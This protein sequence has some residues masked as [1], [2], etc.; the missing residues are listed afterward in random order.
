MASASKVSFVVAASVAAV[1]ALKDQAGLCR[2]NYA[3]RSLQQRAKHGDIAL[4]SRATK[5]SSPSALS[6]WRKGGEGAAER[7]RRT[8]ESLSKRLGRWKISP[9]TMLVVVAAY[10]SST[11]AGRRGAPRRSMAG[12][13]RRHIALAEVEHG[14]ACAKEDA[15][16][17]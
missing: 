15:G 13:E 8:E 17:V 11:S 2:W 7:A 10:A 6:K 3:L 4:F 1:E 12:R 5:R 14:G 9:S 16:G